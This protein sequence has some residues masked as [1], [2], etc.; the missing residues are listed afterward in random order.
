MACSK[1][2]MSILRKPYNT[3]MHGENLAGL[4]M[5]YLETFGP[6]SEGLFYYIALCISVKEAPRD[7]EEP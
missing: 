3:L 4:A 1:F 7:Q 6:D 5:K 2:I